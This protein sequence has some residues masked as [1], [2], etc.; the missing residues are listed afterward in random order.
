MVE[1]VLPPLNKCVLLCPHTSGPFHK[2]TPSDMKTPFGWLAHSL[3]DGGSYAQVAPLQRWCQ[4]G[5]G[6][7]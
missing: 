4:G 1:M 7:S 6:V 3:K 5:H 2:H